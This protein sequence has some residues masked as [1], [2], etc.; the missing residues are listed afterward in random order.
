MTYWKFLPHVRTRSEFVRFI[1]LLAVD[2]E[3]HSAEWSSPTIAGFLD[4]LALWTSATTA[5]AGG[6]ESVS[7]RA[8]AEMLAAARVY[9][10]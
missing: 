2:A 1:G 9:E 3:V 10:A 8:V 6:A 5:S 7:W 4:S